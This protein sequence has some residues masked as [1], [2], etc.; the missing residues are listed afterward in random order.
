M[1][2]FK[3][4]YY[5]LITSIISILVYSCSKEIEPKVEVSQ[6]TVNYFE[7]TM[8]F[9]SEGGSKILNFSSNIKWTLK[10]SDTQNSIA[11]CTTSLISGDAGT[12][13]ITVTVA[14][15]DSMEDRNVVLVLTAGTIIKTVIIN[16]KH[17]NSIILNTN[18]FEIGV[19]GGIINVE[20]KSNIQYTINIPKEY[21]DWISEIESNNS[22]SFTINKHSFKISPSE[23]YD[24]REGK[25]F[26][27]SDNIEE[28]ITVYQAGDT[29]LVLSQNEYKIDSEGGI[30]FI[31]ISSNFEFSV[32]NPSVDWITEN[33]T[34]GISSH[35]LVY[36]IKPN[37]GYNNREALIIIRDTNGEKKEYIKIIQKHKELQKRNVLIEEF[38][39]QL[40]ITGCNGYAILKQI[41]E[42][43]DENIIIVNM[44]TGSLALDDENFG[45]KST[46]GDKYAT[47][48]N[49]ESYPSI[50]INHQGKP[51]H[52]I[53][54]WHSEVMK[55]VTGIADIDIDIDATF[56]DIKNN[57]SVTGRLLSN[58]NTTATFHAWII[59]DN[60]K[61]PQLMPNMNLNTD[62]VHNYV[63]RASVNDIEGENVTLMPE[64]YSYINKSSIICN[65][66]WNKNNIYLIAFVYNESGVLQVKKVPIIH[67]S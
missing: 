64:I 22:R 60:I 23:E 18:K 28:V 37:I 8:D 4:L 27:K 43:Y 5:I 56:D 61:A 40:C 14:E 55:H 62:F 10:V 30:I 6:G 66:K 63:Y 20:T 46:D 39:G 35:T 12:Y 9:E 17:K 42:M 15:N 36:N 2:S 31:D 65:N 16:Q 29:I 53:S 50:L 38:T 47:K 1:N 24:K 3:N 11:W 25:I 67:N 48:W 13:N 45:L 34:R 54:I 7:K 59:E 33:K 32:E 26:F 44:H 41:K 49:V 57:I 51:I 58:K 52:N 21:K 19:K